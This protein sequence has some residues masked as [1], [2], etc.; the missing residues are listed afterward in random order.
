MTSKLIVNSLAADAGVSTITF[1]DQAKMGNAI[2]HSTGFTIGD[3]FLH[4]T[5][6]NI[7]NINA[8][9]VI[10][11][12]KFVGE[13]SVGSSITFEDN[14]KAYFGTG[15]DFSI[16]HN[17]SASYLD[18]TGTGG[19]IVKTDTA[20][21]VFN[22]AGSQA[23]LTVTP[24][25]AVDLYH[26]N[27]KHFE[28]TSDGVRL[29]TGLQMGFGNSDSLEIFLSPP[30]SNIIRQ[31][32][33]ANTFFRAGTDATITIVTDAEVALHYDGSRKFETTNTGAVVTGIVTATSR[34]SLGNNTTNAVDLEFGTNRGSAGDTLANINWK[35]NNTYVAQI[36]G[37]AGSDTTNKDDAHL[38]FYT[39]ASGSLVERLRITSGGKVGIG[40]LIP[41]RQFDVV[42]TAGGG[43]GVIGSN[44]GI[45]MGTH[46]TGGFQVNAA[47]AR[48]AANNYHI[49][50]SAV[51]D[52]CIAAESTKDILFGTGA[53]SSAMVERLRIYNDGRIAVNQPTGTGV[54]NTG[55]VHIKSSASNIGQ[56]YLEQNNATDGF[57]L[58]QD[59]PNG[60]HLKFIRNIGG[61][62]TVNVLFRS[63]RGICFNGDTAAANALDDYEEGTFS[64]AWFD[65]GGVF[66]SS[67]SVQYGQ[68]TK[69]GNVVYFCFGLRIGS[70][71]RTPNSSQACRVGNLPF[72]SRVVG[73]DQEPVFNLYARLWGSGTPPETAWIRQSSGGSGSNH[74]EFYMDESQ[75]G[76]DHR[77]EGADFDTSAS[78]RVV[79][80]GFY[81]T[82]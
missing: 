68:Y 16:Y 46:H 55:K 10:T 59:G 17:G 41:N 14:E 42:D 64:P 67:Y 54:A 79:V 15:T 77:L 29:P 30:S 12:T 57:I 34:V 40:T 47:I 43:I 39:A 73:D 58:N 56:L 36:R 13:V 9:G 2:F 71:S 26:G 5:G 19:L 21:Q 62:Q 72:V 69:I 50:N 28:T 52:L 25:G 38:N 23:A 48:A 76:N 51:G 45:Y 82:S 63:D 80:N 31:M 1:A 70:F 65:D 22:S 18:E 74:V 53:S 11:A 81:F 35:W 4:S 66:V 6:V 24:G 37:M 44:A 20:F 3:S 49:T 75:T 33:G 60:G 7:T 8:T 61:S 27:T 78:C 32:N